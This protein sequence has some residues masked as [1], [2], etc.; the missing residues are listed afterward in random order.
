[1]SGLWDFGVGVSGLGF[2]GFGVG[3]LRFQGVGFRVIGF[4]QGARALGRKRSRPRPYSLT[5]V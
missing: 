2:F 3:V 5:A 1:M 4:V